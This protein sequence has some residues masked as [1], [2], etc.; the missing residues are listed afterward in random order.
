MAA[1]KLEVVNVKYHVLAVPSIGGEKGRS[2]FW[3]IAA[4]HPD[5]CDHGRSSLKPLN[6]LLPGNSAAFLCNARRMAR[7]LRF[8]ELQPWSVSA[9]PTT[10][11]GCHR[12]Q[13]LRPA[14]P[15]QRI[16]GISQ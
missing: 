11:L 13:R 16:G 12:D 6:R 5:T 7:S 15:R 3:R 10:K 4:L 1:Q 8:R 14:K 9:A 2:K